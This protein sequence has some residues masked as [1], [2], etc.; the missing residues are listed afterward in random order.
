MDAVI[1][2]TFLKACRAEK[3]LTQA[4]LAEAL[5]VTAK[6]VSRWE[7]GVGF[8]DIQ[9]L[10]PLAKA[11]DVSLLE[12]MQSRRIGTDTVASQEASEAVADALSFAGANRWSHVL[13]W[14]EG[15]SIAVILAAEFFLIRLVGRFVTGA[16][17]RA[18]AYVTVMLVIL[19]SGFPFTLRRVMES[20]QRPTRRQLIRWGL[21]ALIVLTFLASFPLREL[22]GVSQGNLL[23]LLSLAL[24]CIRDWVFPKEPRGKE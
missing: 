24:L 18:A 6:A 5:H 3:H 15:I 13:R 9:T 14:V 23:R 10:E 21:A 17:M 8:P 12:L 20:P 4:E 7:R 22:V 11:L 2:G 16:W 1:F 19:G